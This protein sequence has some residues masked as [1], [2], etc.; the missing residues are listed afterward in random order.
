MSFLVGV[1]GKPNA[2]K[3]TFFSA[4]TMAEAKIA[5][6]P[7]TTLKPN[8][9]VGYVRK[10]CPHKE[11]GKECN[12]RDSFCRDGV[13]FIPV[14]LLD[15][16]GLVPEAHT[17]RG[18]G[19]QFLDDLRTADG[20]IHVVDASGTS[21]LEGNPAED[22]DPAAEVRFLQR[23]LEQ[24][25]LSIIERNWKKVRG[26]GIAELSDVLTGLKVTQKQAE[27]IAKS[28]SLPLERIDWSEDERFRFAEAI[29]RKKPIVVAANKCDLGG[30][31]GKLEKEFPERKIVPCSAVYELVLRKA[32]KAGNIEYFPGSPEFKV[33]DA[34]GKQEEALGKIAEYLSSHRSTGVQEALEA[35]VFGGLGAISAFP[36]EDENKWCDR[37]GAVLP[38]V[39]LLPEGSTPVDLAERVHSSLAK[40]FIAAVDGRTKMRLGKD[41]KLKDRDILKII[42]GR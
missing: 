34:S 35:L 21:D 33:K 15:V 8:R 18:L 20:F 42:S 26:R 22:A 16:A 27:G 29:F 24:W 25:F 38:N 17:G 6:F 11:A 40:N 1:V 36:V 13:R 19:F 37:K 9:G 7:F 32:E 12:P 3:S 23:E 41:Y 10:E 39:H 31:L 2:G 14:E 4:L 5:S 28:L 30:D